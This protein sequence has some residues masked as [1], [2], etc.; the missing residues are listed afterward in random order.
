MRRAFVSIDFAETRP[1]AEIWVASLIG[2]VVFNG[3]VTVDVGVLR[4]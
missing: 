3:A 4:R 2:E 1:L